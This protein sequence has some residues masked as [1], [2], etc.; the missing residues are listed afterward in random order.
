MEE[1][2]D[3]GVIWITLR[4][5]VFGLWKSYPCHWVWLAWH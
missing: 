2:V 1:T 3:L 5:I 4:Y